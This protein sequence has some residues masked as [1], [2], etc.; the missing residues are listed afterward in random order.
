MVLVATNGTGSRVSPAATATAPAA[1]VT[2]LHVD[3]RHVRPQWSRLPIV[4]WRAQARRVVELAANLRS[5]NAS[6]PLHC[7]LSGRNQSAVNGTIVRLL[8]QGVR[9]HTTEPPVPAWASRMHQASFAKLALINASFQLGVR[10]VY[11]DTDVLLLRNIDHLASAL[12]PHALGVTF[13]ADHELVNSGV[14]SLHVSSRARLHAAWSLMAKALAHRPWQSCS[15]DGSD[16]Q[17]WIYFLGRTTERLLELPMS[18]NL[19][20]SQV[21]QHADTR[22]YL[23]ASEVCTLSVPWLSSCLPARPCPLC[24]FALKLSSCSRDRLGAVA[25]ASGRT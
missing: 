6:L 19:Y 18:Y 25:G 15:G 11:L 17:A 14:L 22:W 12:P 4:Q 1:F 9:F 2:V 3:D 7:L 5:V 13:R 21:E 20:P 8:Q 10:L 24:A 23:L 16:Q